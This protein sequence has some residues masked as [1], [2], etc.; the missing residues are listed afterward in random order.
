M[1]NN[2]LQHQYSQNVCGVKIA[3]LGP[4]P[5][6]L[7]GVSVHIQRVIDVLRRQKNQVYH[8]DT[9]V[10]YRYRY[11]PYYLAR[12][13][14]WLFE[15]RP[16]VVHYHTLYLSNNLAEI[17]LLVR[18]KKILGYT[19]TFVEHDC[20]HMYERSVRFKN[21]YNCILQSV[22]HLVLIGSLTY[23]SYKD[24]QFMLPQST[25][26]E[27]AFL[28]PNEKTESCILATY[29]TSLHAF[30]YN[31]SPLILGN[32]FQLSH[33]QGRDLY[34]VDLCLQ[35]L[36]EIVLDYPRVGFIL[37]LAQIGDVHYFRQLCFFAHKMHIADKIYIL[38]NQKELW[39]LMKKVDLFVRPT[40]S[41]GASVSVQE[42]LYF[43]V[44]AVVSDVCVRPARAILFENQNV[45]DFITKVRYALASKRCG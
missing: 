27:A 45:K 40:R 29:P 28:P 3:V 12:L 41:D 15:H 18:L 42:A 35:M 6:P 39:P 2:E 22:D 38:S 26:V 24:A 23:K 36:A 32:A 11:F 16:H 44:P 43:G 4:C 10:E 7:G 37:A 20:R 19:L 5:P 25:S 8:F 9:T 21:T 33:V 34:G 17:K 13:A 14:Y 30:V 31:H 1:V